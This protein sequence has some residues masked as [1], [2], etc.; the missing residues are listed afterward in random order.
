MIL[1]C[2]FSCLENLY[3]KSRE[4][5]LQQTTLFHLGFM[6]VPTNTCLPCGGPAKF[7]CS[8]VANHTIYVGGMNTLMLG[9]GG[10]LW[11]IETTNGMTDKLH[12]TDP[13]NVPASYEFMYI[14][15][16]N[17]VKEITGLLVRDTNSTWS[18]TT[19]QCIAY[20]PLNTEVLNNSSE[21]VTLEVGGECRI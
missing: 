14:E 6:K 19:L 17:G 21:P 5:Y 4:T 13:K 20:T 3:V 15:H 2:T 7:N 9:P 18:G 10:Q 1:A 16:N 12:S 11:R 8:T